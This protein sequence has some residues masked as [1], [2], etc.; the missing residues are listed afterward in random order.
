MPVIC[1]SNNEIGLSKKLI[2]LNKSIKY[3][4]LVNKTSILDLIDVISRAELVITNETSATHI[5]ASVNTLCF[6]ILGGGHFRR[7]A[8]YP[9]SLNQTQNKVIFNKL[10]CFNCNWYCSIIK[11]KDLTY[12]CINQIS[13]SDLI[14]Q[15]N[16]ELN[17][18]N[19][20]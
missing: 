3:T 1:G 10:E 11:N 2:E 5:A 7:F 18:K 16:K 17:K 13:S 6:T 8:P 15:I 14:S 20:F 12:P 9:K 4:T 19:H